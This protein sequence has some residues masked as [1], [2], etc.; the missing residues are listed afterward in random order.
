MAIEAPQHSPITRHANNT[1]FV[2]CENFAF[3]PANV[4][5]FSHQKFED[6]TAVTTVNFK[7]YTQSIPDPERR[8]FDFL[9]SKLHPKPT[10][11]CP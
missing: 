4:D 5:G 8:L 7:S 6:G 2:L 9:I 10:D 11:E 1:D 3:R